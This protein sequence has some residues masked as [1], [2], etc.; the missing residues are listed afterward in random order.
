MGKST[1][2]IVFNAFQKSF[3]FEII[4]W[5]AKFMALFKASYVSEMVFR[6][7]KKNMHTK[8]WYKWRWILGEMGSHT[9]CE[10]NHKSRNYAAIVDHHGIHYIFGWYEGEKWVTLRRI[11]QYVCNSKLDR[12][13]TRNTARKKSNIYVSSTSASKQQIFQSHHEIDRLFA[14]INFSTENKAQTFRLQTFLWLCCTNF[15][16]RM[17]TIKCIRFSSGFGIPNTWL[18]KDLFVKQFMMIHT[19]RQ[20]HIRIIQLK[21]THTH[22]RAH[23]AWIV[24]IFMGTLCLLVWK[25]IAL[26]FENI[27]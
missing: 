17:E 5:I 8:Q 3:V 2:T 20:T 18:Q 15:I 10:L 23:T 13:L 1:E 27:L 21:K 4:I 11:I 12:Y 24:C 26:T 6:I 16:Y 25:I 22:P 14:L 7:Q 19:H 9:H